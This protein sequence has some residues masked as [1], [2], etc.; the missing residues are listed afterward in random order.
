MVTSVPMSDGRDGSDAEL[1]A[2]YGKRVDALWAMAQELE[3]PPA[4][5][6]R[7]INEVLFSSL[8]RKGNVDLDTWLA[9]SMRCAAKRRAERAQ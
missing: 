9:A 8:L 3:I 7:L 2:L 4:E 6:V 1:M 5:A